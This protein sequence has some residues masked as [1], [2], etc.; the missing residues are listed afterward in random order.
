M[1]NDVLNAR[2]QFTDANGNPYSNGSLEFYETQTSTLTN[3]YTDG[4][5]TIPASNP[6]P[7][8]A[9]GYLSQDNLYLP[10]G[11]YKLIVKDSVGGE[12]WSRDPYT[13]GTAASIDGFIGMQLM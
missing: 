7:L 6:Q 8:D 13:V 12:V 3:V 1:S 5:L 11:V 4:A 9:G 10:T 2:V